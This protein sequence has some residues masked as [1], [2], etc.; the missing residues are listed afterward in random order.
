MADTVSETK[1]NPADAGD[2][3]V[4][5]FPD[6]TRAV[7]GEGEFRSLDGK[8]LFVRSGNRIEIRCPRSKS[9]Y[10]VEWESLG[11]DSEESVT[12]RSLP[13]APD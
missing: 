1:G 3:I 4:V 8:L 9:I 7:L 2:D 11:F 6:G 5:V 13:V 10:G 12:A